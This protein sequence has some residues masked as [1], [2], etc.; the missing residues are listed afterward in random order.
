MNPL[1]K[2]HFLENLKEYQLKII[3]I[4][5]GP[6]GMIA[7][8][9][10]AEC[11]AKVVLLEKKNKLGLKLSL[12]GKGKCN[13]TNTEPKIATFIENYGR[14]GK[15]LINGFHKYF[16][17]DLI[18][19][20]KKL[21]L[22][23]TEQSGG[24]I[25]PKSMNAWDVVDTLKFYLKRNN[26]EVQ[27]ERSAT[28]ILHYKNKVG[29]VITSEGVILADKVILAAGGASYPQTGSDGD[30]CKLARKS[31]HHITSIYPAL[32][33]LCLKNVPPKI[34]DLLLKNVSVAIFSDKKKLAE[35]FGEF[36]FTEFGA[37]GSIAL[38]LSR[39]LKTEINR[40]NLILKIDLKPALSEEKLHNR[41]IREADQHGKEKFEFLLAQLLP[42]QLIAVVGNFA[43]INLEKRIAEISKNERQ[44]LVECLKGLEFTLSG[45]RPLKE[46]IVTSGGVDLKQI[47]PQNMESKIISGLFFAGEVLD[48]DGDTGGYNL[49]AAFTTGYVAGEMAAKNISDNE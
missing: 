37:D 24:R 1:K 21:G 2:N 39:K 27:F 28:E 49:Q 19:L 15:F 43:G 7:A 29:G 30:G 12:T 42:S 48:I 36:F 40:K 38:K 17:S 33:P 32:V 11:G 26:V 3:V 23:L 9:R 18:K 25:Y 13:L 31:G 16:N 46:A 4:G 5:G 41:I 47:D 8:G 22:Q 14:N 20:L 45:T 44:K 10:A 34:V 6:A 35:E